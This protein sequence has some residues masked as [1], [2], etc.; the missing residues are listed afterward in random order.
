MLHCSVGDAR[1]ISL[2]GT[3]AGWHQ[4]VFDLLLVD[5]DKGRIDRQQVVL[6]PLFAEKLAQGVLDEAK[7]GAM[8]G[9]QRVR[10]ARSSLS[11]REHSRV[12]ALECALDHDP[13]LLENILLRCGR[14]KDVVE[15]EVVAANLCHRRPLSTR[16][17][18]HSPYHNLLV[19]HCRPYPRRT[20][21]PFSPSR[22]SLQKCLGR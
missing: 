21:S 22:W 14:L 5:F 2:G 3:P 19:R 10:L 1:E 12:G 9:S 16:A 11:V 13:A 6:R 7:V 17:C 4:E 8:R 20:L 15:L 18:H